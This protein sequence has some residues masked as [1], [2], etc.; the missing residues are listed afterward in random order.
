LEVGLAGAGVD[1]VGARDIGAT[2]IDLTGIIGAVPE[3]AGDACTRVPTVAACGMSILKPAALHLTPQRCEVP[4]VVVDALAR[5]QP[6]RVAS[7]ITACTV[8]LAVP[9]V[10]VPNEL[11]L[12][13]AGADTIATCR[14]GVGDVRA[15][16]LAAV[17][18]VVPCKEVLT[19]AV[20]EAVE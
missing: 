14:R 6:V 10:G 19:I 2:T 17:A 13:A 8:D 4:S 5:V 18:R 9:I 15:V 20:V 1:A 12:T 16:D 11:T 3:E 7:N